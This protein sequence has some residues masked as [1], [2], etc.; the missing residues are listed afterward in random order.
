[1]SLPSK[2]EIFSL[3]N[4]SPQRPMKILVSACLGGDLC[5]VDGTSNG[6]Y[7]W[8]K[9]LIALSNVEAI[10]FCPEAYSFGIP[11]SLPDIHD[12]NGFDVLDGKAKVLGDRGEDMTEGMVLAANEMLR[13]AKKANVDMAILMDMSAACGS[14]V[15]SDGCRLVSNRKYQKGPGVAAALLI[16]NNIPV[17]CQRDFKTLEFIYKKLDP[18]HVKNEAA[19]D[20]H[21]S[22]WYKEYF[23]N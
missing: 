1:M 15:I 13:L 14:Q 5:G 8:I 3:P 6:E 23:R 10:K 21:E 19:I 2:E 11:R 22:L 9:K 18:A 7:P 16:R 17:V 4:F 20:H 12:G